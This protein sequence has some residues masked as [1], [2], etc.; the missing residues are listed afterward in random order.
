[1]TRI[2]D[3]ADDFG[4]MRADR[5]ATFWLTLIFA[6]LMV[7]VTAYVLSAAFLNPDAS[8]PAHRSAAIVHARS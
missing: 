1:M 6:T 7:A 3:H 4:N 2:E 8:A 5:R